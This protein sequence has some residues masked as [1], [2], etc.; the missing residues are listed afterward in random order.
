M[1]III[2]LIVIAIIAKFAFDKNE[3]NQRVNKQGGMLNKFKVL[4][5]HFTD[6][7]STKIFKVT[8]DTVILGQSGPSGSTTFTIM[9]AFS[10]VNIK[11]KVES[12]VFGNHG[13]EWEFHEYKDQ[14]EMAEIIGRELS[15]YQ[16]N[17]LSK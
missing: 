15:I 17:V 7:D 6:A 1:W 4:I 16:E 5:S 11:W 9:Q 8:N 13:L 14:N 12:I 10:K 2:I 3:V